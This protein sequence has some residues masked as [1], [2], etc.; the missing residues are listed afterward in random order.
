MNV[1]YD[2]F[3]TTD[4]AEILGVDKTTVSLWCQN[5][6]IR[7]QDVSEPGS[8]RPR[9][10]FTN[11]EVDRIKG[12]RAKYGRR[13]WVNYAKAELQKKTKIAEAVPAKTPVA[14]I[15]GVTIMEEKKE[16]TP[17]N[18]KLEMKIDELREL[19]EELANIE[20]RRNQILNQI[21][22]V[23]DEIVEAV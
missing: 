3:N 17:M 21:E 6:V 11:E 4:V 13:T 9:Y 16:T 12:L 19:K 8:Q 14:H 7:Y 22:L 2:S 1:K 15:K 18:N 23:K 5:G 20:A 10:L